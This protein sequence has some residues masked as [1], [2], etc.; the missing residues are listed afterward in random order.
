MFLVGDFRAKFGGHSAHSRVKEVADRYNEFLVP[1]AV[2]VGH[3]RCGEDVRIDVHV[4]GILLVGAL[5]VFNI[6]I[7]STEALAFDAE[8]LLQSAGDD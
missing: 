6:Q 4:L 1:V 8:W 3:G 2:D 7:T 5:W